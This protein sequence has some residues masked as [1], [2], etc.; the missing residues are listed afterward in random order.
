MWSS[1]PPP[2]ARS[3]RGWAM[4]LVACFVAGLVAGCRGGAARSDAQ[5]PPAL[6]V[7]VEL[8]RSVSVD[9]TTEYVAILRSRDSAV[10]MPQVEGEITRIYV[11]SGERVSPGTPLMQ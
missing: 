11:R 8:A 10:I 1:W 6:A 4:A 2:L 7:K 5:A 3:R 9:E